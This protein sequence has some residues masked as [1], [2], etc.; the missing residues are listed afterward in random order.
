[1]GGEELSIWDL[2]LGDLIIGKAVGAEEDWAGRFAMWWY[3][4]ACLTEFKYEVSFWLSMASWM[5][6]EPASVSP[7]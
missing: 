6:P 5:P 4:I 7:V 2:R 1:M 3:Y